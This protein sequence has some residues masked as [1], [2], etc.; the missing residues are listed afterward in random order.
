MKTTKRKRKARARG[1]KAAILANRHPGES[2]NKQAIRLKVNYMTLS[3]AER[4]NF[5]PIGSAGTLLRA[6][7]GLSEVAP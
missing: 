3:D 6:A 4:S 5:W 7:L 1:A 2:R